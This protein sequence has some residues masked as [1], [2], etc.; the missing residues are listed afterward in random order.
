MALEPSNDRLYNKLVKYRN[1]IAEHAGVVPRAVM[2]DVVLRSVADRQPVTESTLLDVP[3]VSRIFVEKYGK[4]FLE[5]IQKDL[6]GAFE[7][8]KLTKVAKD[9]Y[10]LTEKKLSIK[11]ISTKMFINENLTLGYLKECAI[12]GARLDVETYFDQSEFE[13]LQEF[14]DANPD[15]DYKNARNKSGSE[16]SDPL[17][18]LAFAII[19]KR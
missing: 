18:R 15:T 9:I 6:A 14:V 12:N 10:R 5:E 17:L 1:T 16:M 3:G 11:E 4:L 2:I 19:T 8:D 7:V 13:K